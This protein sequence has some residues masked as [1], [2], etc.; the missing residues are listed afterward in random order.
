MR[1]PRLLFERYGR[2][3]L[4]DGVS[5]EGQ[6]RLGRLCAVLAHDTSEVAR[7][8]AHACGRWLVGAGVGRLVVTSGGADELRALDADLEVLPSPA[9]AEPPCA[10]FWFARR[11]YGAS[12]DV[13]LTDEPA[14]WA[15]GRS[16]AARVT[17]LRWVVGA[18]AQPEDAVA[19]GAAAADLLVADALGLEPMPLLLTVDWSNP[20]DP[21]SKRTPRP[22][23]AVPVGVALAADVAPLLPR[24][25][26]LPAEW[27]RIEAEVEA[28]YPN[29]ACGFVV[30]D[31][32]GNL[33][34]VAAPNLQDRYHALD[35][36]SYPRTARTAYKL[37]ERAVAKAESD[38]AELV[39]I[40]HSHCDAGAYFSAEDVR[41][42]APGGVALFPG[43]AYLVLAVMGGR[44][45][46]VA[47]YHFDA[48]SGGFAAELG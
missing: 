48:T 1:D 19:L 24:L 6:A 47:M 23:E 25:R 29:E 41:C 30:R 39:C 2:Q 12:V 36:E 43:V 20:A 4:V 31:T 15:T 16:A 26:A 8:A 22:V 3:L 7:S 27:G 35:P 40:W 9:D 13:A 18:P 10:Q 33:C 44:V 42:A 45:R 38:G 37:N 11:D 34:S 14:G 17:T 32:D 21:H 5:V 46:G 28:R